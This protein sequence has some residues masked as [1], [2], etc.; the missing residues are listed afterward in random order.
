MSLEGLLE[1]ARWNASLYANYRPIQT[2]DLM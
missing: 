2:G 1:E